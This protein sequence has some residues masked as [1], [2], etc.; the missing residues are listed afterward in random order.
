MDAIKKVLFFL[1]FAVAMIV[2]SARPVAAQINC[3]A[4]PSPC[5][6]LT[7]KLA[8]SNGMPA[9]NF[10][11]TFQPSQM[12]FV[13]GSGVAVSTSTTCATS[14]D[15]SVVGIGNPLN[16]TNV[17]P[18]YFGTLPPG[19][20]YVQYTFY[21]N[22][23]MAETLPSPEQ[24]VQLAS[25]GGLTVNPP[26][27]GI[28]SGAVGMKVYIGSTPGGETLQ[29]STT[30]SASFTISTP[31]AAGSATPATNSTV[32]QQVANDA[33]WPTGTGY[34]VA[35]SDSSG[36]SYPGYPMTWQLIG[37]GTT[38]NLSNGLPYYH[39]T[40]IFP[41][42][43]LA[44]PLN[45]ATQSIAGALSLGS[46]AFYAGTARVGQ[47]YSSGSID[48]MGGFTV[49]G[50]APSGYCLVGNGTSYV[51]ANCNGILLQTNGTNN[52]NQSKLN[53]QGSGGTV[54][55][56]SGT[57]NITISSPPSGV[58]TLGLIH[59]QLS[60]LYSANGGTIVP[61]DLGLGS[62]SFTGT[63][64]STGL[65]SGTGT[66]LFGFF[67]TAAV[68]AAGGMTFRTRT[69]SMGTISE[70]ASR[71]KISSTTSGRY[72]VGFWDDNNNYSS[73]FATN[74]N[75]PLVN[76]G[77]GAVVAFR[78]SYG[79]DTTWHAYVQTDPNNHYT[80]VD[81]GVV[82][83]ASSSHLF[84]IVPNGSGSVKFYI[85]GALVATITSANVPPLSALM[86]P[87]EAVDANGA[88]APV[89]LTNYYVSALLSR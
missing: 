89:T 43:I 34:K 45:H 42:P 60:T 14:S 69:F 73:S 85:D 32:C 74:N 17:S 50:Q 16:A 29:G 53:I 79:Y 27:S 18:V 64:I 46:Y 51:G 41:A 22:S 59:N 44:S 37:P 31:L 21:V 78:Y 61:V 36:N 2:L 75:V 24:T 58:G 3:Q 11:L 8:S 40:V 83:D 20:Y 35:L 68:G 15:G 39:G 70:Y 28:P 9:Q 67:A 47:V 81:T 4:S 86:S 63:G 65:I 48:S 7:G 12:F 80:D 62:P 54:V 10:T 6:T 77:N 55:T 82:P 66:E 87:V 72:W 33:G 19:T 71:S 84:E 13:A 56:D 57:G 26:V 1:M 23:P 49:N 5:V 88:A 52:F 76:L 38:I 25:S 30:G